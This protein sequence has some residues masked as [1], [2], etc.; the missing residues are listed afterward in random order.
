[1]GARHAGRQAA[2]QML[3]QAEL[4]RFD[5]DQ[6]IPDFWRHFEADPEGRQYADALVRGVAA[7]REEIDQ[8]I[9]KASVNWRLERMTAVDRNVLRLGTYELLVEQGTPRAVILDEAVELAKQFG[10]ENSGPFVNGVLDR[11]AVTLNRV[12]RDRQG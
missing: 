7:R 3:F 6:V 10:A 5:A 8:L 1:M 11:V 2:L 12:D 4:G 9:A